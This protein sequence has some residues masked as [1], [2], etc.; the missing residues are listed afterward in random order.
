M[1]HFKITVYRFKGM[2]RNRKGQ[3]GDKDYPLQ[4]DLSNAACS[5]SIAAEKWQLS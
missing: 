1:L 4:G 3:L 2:K 5:D